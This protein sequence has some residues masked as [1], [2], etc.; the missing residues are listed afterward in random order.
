MNE[1]ADAE[2]VAWR[3]LESTLP[4]RDLPRWIVRNA[5]SSKTE[6]EDGSG[7]LWH[8]CF[9]SASCGQGN[10]GRDSQMARKCLFVLIKIA[11]RK[12]TF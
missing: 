8:T 9:V 1:A 3:S 11:A 10:R 5:A 7:M 6:R 2:A 12:S 4:S